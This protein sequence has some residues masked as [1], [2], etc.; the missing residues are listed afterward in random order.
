M[1]K[2][3]SKIDNSFMN[4]LKDDLKSETFKKSFY[5][6]LLKLQIAEEIIKFRK[7]RQLSQSELAKAINTT[8]AVISRIENTQVCPNTNILERICNEFK[9]NIKLEF[10]DMQNQ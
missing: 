3:N 1:K 7:K 8:Q 2:Q 4:D 10:Q 6:E 5:G 9:I